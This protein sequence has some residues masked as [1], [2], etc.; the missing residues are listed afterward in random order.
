VILNSSLREWSPDVVAHAVH[1][2]MKV[3]GRNEPHF[4]F[5]DAVLYISEKHM[6]RLPDGRPAHG[7]VIY[8]A[9]GALSAPWKMQFVNRIAH[10]WSLMRTGAPIA[11]DTEDRN[12]AP[13]EDIPRSMPLHE[14]WRL[15]Y[16]RDPYLQ[17]LTVERLRLMFQ[18]T[19][20]VNSL[21]FLKGSWPKP[22]RQETTEGIRIFTHIIEETNRRGID[23]R[24]LQFDLLTAAEKAQVYAGLPDELARQVHGPT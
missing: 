15:E 10:E 22:S 14:R 12:F 21:T 16:Q 7:I 19:I 24:L 17:R 3:N 23:V 2:K 1:S 13:I 6:R 8:E 4:Q 11:F 5:I 9:P 18:R 20:A